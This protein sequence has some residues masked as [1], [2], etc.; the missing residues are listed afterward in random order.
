MV[1]NYD[2]L[3]MQNIDNQA[4]FP[5]WLL[6][7]NDHL[8]QISFGLLGITENFD[9][10]KKSRYLVLNEG[11]TLN[12][13]GALAVINMLNASFNQA[14]RTTNLD[15]EKISKLTVGF[16]DDLMFHLVRNKRKYQLDWRKLRSLVFTLTNQYNIML[17]ASLD[18]FTLQRLTEKM[19]VKENTHYQQQE[20]KTGIRRLMG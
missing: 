13:E 9:P 6:D 17:N 2:E 20:N 10:E 8:K 7:M 5:V 18:G 19:Q 11:A 16:A 3:V 15:A 14:T 4:S 1:N 12:A